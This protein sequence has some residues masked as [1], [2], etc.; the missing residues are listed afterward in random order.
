MNKTLRGQF[1]NKEE[2]VIATAELMLE[3]QVRRW[4]MENDLNQTMEIAELMLEDQVRRWHMEN[5]LNQSLL[6]QKGL[7]LRVEQQCRIIELANFIN[8]DKQRTIIFQR[9]VMLLML[10]L[11]MLFSHPKVQIP[12]RITL[13]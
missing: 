8:L 13:T 9:I 3:D 12:G 5:D 11:K 7:V 6:K 2:V 1:H 10:K 4:H